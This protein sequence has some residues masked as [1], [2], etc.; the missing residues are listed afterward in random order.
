MIAAISGEGIMIRRVLLASALA[1]LAMASSMRPAAAVTGYTLVL[2]SGNLDQDLQ[3]WVQG[4]DQVR[5]G[6]PSSGVPL[7]RPYIIETPSFWGD[8]GGGAHWVTPMPDGSGPAGGYEYFTEFTPP[9]ELLSA[10]LDMVWRGDDVVTPAINGTR[11]PRDGSPVPGAA[12][13][14]LQMDLMPALQPGANRLSFFVENYFPAGD[15]NPTGIDFVAN[16][17]YTRVPTP[18]ELS[19]ATIASGASVNQDPEVWVQGSDGVRPGLSSSGLPRQHPSIMHET[20]PMYSDIG[21][22]AHWL[23]PLPNGT[24]PAGGYEYYTEFSLPDGFLAATLDVKWLADSSATLAINGIR[25]P[26]AGTGPGAPGLLHL[27]L[28]PF[29][30]PGT[31]RLSFLVENGHPVLG[32]TGVDFLATIFYTR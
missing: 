18:T 4:R 31:N 14:L 21:G 13:G 32:S 2:K 25:I 8:V 29:I 16:I 17:Y 19:T 20:P 11:L 6:L 12:P 30:Q 26:G 28:R 1:L 22:G 5:P 3:L 15:I 9:D 24:G 23:T 7:G 27:D 10:T